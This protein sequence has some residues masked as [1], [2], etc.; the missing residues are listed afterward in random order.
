MFEEEKDKKSLFI[1]DFNT[2]E[3]TFTNKIFRYFYSLFQEKKEFKLFWKYIQILIETFQLI[4]YSFSSNHYNSWKLDEKKIK[5]ISNIVGIFRVSVLIQ[6]LNYKIYTVIFYVLLILIF[7]FC[8]IVIIQLIFIDSNSIKYRLSTTIIRSFIDIISI[9]CYIPFTEIILIPIKCID[10]KVYGLKNAETCWKKMH[11]LILVLGIIGAILLFIWCL[12][13]MNFSF[14]PFQ[15]L[16][17]SIR[18]NSNNDIINLFLKLFLILQYLL[19]S[20]EYISLVILFLASITMTISNYLE[21]SYNS[22]HLEL[23]VTIKNL[24]ILWTYFVLFVSKIFKNFITNGF[25]YLLVLGYPIIIYFSYILHKERI[26]ETKYFFGN[27]KNINEYIQ[28]IKFYIKIVDSFIN[29]NQ[30]ILRNNNE[31]E[32]QRNIILLK[33]YIEFH[34]I[35]CTNK[36][37]PLG[38]FLKNE[39]NF[40]TQRQC[41]LNYINI[42]F[43]KGFKFFPDNVSLLILY[44]QFNLSKKFNLNKVK[45]NFLHLKKLKCTI[46]QKYIIYCMEQ[47]LKNLNNNNNLDTNSQIDLNEQKYRKLKL[48]IENSISLY[49]EFWGIFSTTITSNINISKLYYIGGK[50]NYHLNEI[51]MLWDELKNKRIG[52]E[53][54]NIVQLYSKFLLEILWDRNKSLEVF[55][56]IND[57]NLHNYHLNDKKNSEKNIINEDSIEALLDNEDYLLFC[58]YDERINFK[59]K[60]CST[61][62]CQLLGYEK[63]DIIGKSLAIIFPNV[64]LEQYLKNFKNFIQGSN[65]GKN[66]QK[67]LSYS[68]N[69]LNKNNKIIIVRNR[70]G[71]IIPLFFS[72][73]IIEDNDYSDSILIKI[74]FENKD[75]K[76]EYPYYILTKSDLSV[77]NISSSAINL[78]LSLDLLKKYLVKMDVLI[79][80]E[81]DTILNLYDKYNEYEEEPKEVIWVFPHMI[82]PKDNNKH[83]KIEEMEELIDK[84]NKKRFN[85]Q[86]KAMRLSEN[87]NMEFIFRFTDI[88]Y[89]KYNK[90]L[91]D[92][93]YIQKSDKKL[94]MYDLFNLQYIRIHLVKKKTGIRNLRNEEEENDLAEVAEGTKIKNIK[95]K[96]K[97]IKNFTIDEECSDEIEIEIEEKNILTKEKVIELQSHNFIQIRNFIFNLP[98]Y[99]QDVI[100]EKF[101]PNGDKYSASKLTEPSIK[102]QLN[103]FCQRIDNLNKSDKQNKKRKNIYVRDV[104]INIDSPKSSNNRNNLV[105][106]N[107]H[108]STDSTLPAS[109]NNQM[110]DINKSLSTNLTESIKNVFKVNSIKY[111]KT[112]IFSAFLTIFLLVLFAF[113]F[114]NNHW[115]VIKIKIEY[116]N[117]GY[118]IMNDILYTKAVITEG[119]ISNSYFLYFPALISGGKSFFLKDIQTELYN[120]RQEFTQT[121][122]T[123][124]SNKVCKE[125]KRFIKNTKIEMYSLTL[126][127]PEKISIL[128]N[129]ALNRIPA[130]MNDI[131]V[132]TNL[133]VM[134]NRDTYE[135]MYNLINEFYINWDKAIDILL[136]DGFNATKLRHPIIII[137]TIDLII[138]IIIFLFFLNLLSRFSQDRERP[139]NLFL[140]IKKQVFENLKNSAEIFSNKLLNKFFGNDDNEDEIQQDYQSN[141]NP[142]DINIAKF[143]AANEYKYSIKN[144]FSYCSIIIIIF[145]FFLFYLAYFLLLSIDFTHRMKNLFEFISLFEKTNTAQT[146]FVLSIDIFKSYLFDKSIPILNNNKT[147]EEFFKTF[148]NITN[149]LEES[150]IYTSKTTSFLSGKYLEKYRQYLFGD[151]SELLDKDYYEENKNLLENKIKNGLIPVLIRNIELLRFFILKYCSLGE[152]TSGMS[153]IL[154]SME[155][156]IAET[157]LTLKVTIRKWYKSVLY[158]MISSFDDYISESNLI[159]II[160]FICMVIILVLYYFIVWKTFEEKLIILMK[161]S[162]DL[163]NLIPQEIKNIIIEK[164][165]E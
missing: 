141:I 130:S 147:K 77:E 33:G 3:K 52:N 92:K 139:I 105:S 50:L 17:S 65:L 39:G 99:G 111:I 45:A 25:I 16:K 103:A 159:F 26:F 22:N 132:D 82:Y 54:Q 86:I 123:F 36:E 42:L 131:A 90:K 156:K 83:I 129:S 113:L 84:S 55:K 76:S 7:I 135:L 53:Y 107:R 118:I 1:H 48:L 85:L 116:I 34:S 9:I 109:N 162:S 119:V 12:F 87:E 57:E 75:L 67:D 19:I 88:N 18:I 100:L 110:E 20:N 138:S 152:E 5:T 112:L 59:I 157:F 28:S 60:Q 126:E 24:M 154:K 62:I 11:Y 98:V 133:L 155:F 127:K 78:G 146:D 136:Q 38:K 79:R 31:N 153:S 124:T 69:D 2:N 43:N 8:L 97:K 56:K 72:I 164:F 149:K 102:I 143:K 68:E 51:N 30:F 128:L 140:T 64:L 158:L 21:P 81:E 41:L 27:I 117:N 32:G 125:F 142:N 44:I 63:Y 145:V 165:N 35:A 134:N 95:K 137:M 122:D 23:I 94:I 93:K 91:D 58:D 114:S 70:M 80:T 61:S 47:N 37:C 120:Y 15:K 49:D 4:S 163:I 144:A 89:N 108:D 150:I 96:F 66:N 148:I 40:N 14:Y 160:V 13:M 74:K 10:G 73:K 71:Y 151:F 46:K 115:K 121:F 6:Y 106:T 161:E 101:R 29:R 104:S